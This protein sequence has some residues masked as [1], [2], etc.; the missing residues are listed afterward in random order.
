[1]PGPITLLPCVGVD[2]VHVPQIAEAIQQQG[3]AYLSRV[4]TADELEYAQRSASEL[5]RRLAARFA[6]K[7]ATLK[8]L[9][10]EGHWLDWRCIE[11]LRNPHG[12]C[13]L[14]LSGAA[15]ALAQNLHLTALDLSLSHEG[16]YAIAV[17][18][19]LCQRP[20]LPPANF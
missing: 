3:A 2:L 20:P 16:D 9:R 4:F 6:A 15:L 13:T 10:P 5:A 18:T 14:R 12:H 8:L 19:G 11:V 1:M 17:V 7:E